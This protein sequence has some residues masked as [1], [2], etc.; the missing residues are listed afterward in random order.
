MSIDDYSPSYDR[1]RPSCFG[2]AEIYNLGSPRCRDCHARHGCAAVVL[3]KRSAAPPPVSA[4]AD[5]FRNYA[6]RVNTWHTPP[7][8]ANV[9]RPA[10]AY[11]QYRQRAVSSPAAVSTYEQYR[12]RQAAPAPGARVDPLYVKNPLDLPVQNPSPGT[13]FTTALVFNAFLASTRAV[14]VEALIASDEIPRMSYGNPFA[15]LFEQAPEKK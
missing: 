2:D 5:R 13:R 9:P 6:P 14:L 4:Y 12:Q 3:P 11:E 8:P 10:T 1:S 7:A 15:S